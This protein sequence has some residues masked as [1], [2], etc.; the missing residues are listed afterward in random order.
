M[1]CDDLLADQGRWALTQED[2]LAHLQNLHVQEARNMELMEL[3]TLL[4]KS[5]IDDDMLDLS[6]EDFIFVEL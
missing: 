1:K 2:Q 6:S 3:C 5:G 4:E